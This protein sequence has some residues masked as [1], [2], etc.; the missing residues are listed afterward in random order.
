MAELVNGILFKV[1]I[2][3]LK[4]TIKDADVNHTWKRTDLFSAKGNIVTSA[5]TDIPKPALAFPL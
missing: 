3:I 1:N 2:F 5:R 4:I